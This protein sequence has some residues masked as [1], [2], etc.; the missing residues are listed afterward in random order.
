MAWQRKDGVIFSW[1]NQPE[2]KGIFDPAIIRALQHD[3]KR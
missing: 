2:L 3:H 1:A